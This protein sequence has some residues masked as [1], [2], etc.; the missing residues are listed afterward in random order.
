LRLRELTVEERTKFDHELAAL[1]EL[2]KVN[3]NELKRL[4]T[5]NF[6][7]GAFAFSILFIGFLFYVLHIIFS[8]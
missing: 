8:K 7:T 6:K 2:L 4:Q 5:E 1:K 3:E